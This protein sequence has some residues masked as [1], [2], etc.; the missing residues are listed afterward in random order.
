MSNLAY[1]FIGSG[2]FDEAKQLCTKAKENSDYNERIDFALA[3]IS[4][5]KTE[6]D[7]KE[8]DLVNNTKKIRSFYIEYAHTCSKKTLTEFSGKFKGPDC[9]LDVIIEN[10]KF[11]AIGSFEKTSITGGWASAFA[12]RPIG[13][14]LVP[15]SPAPEE[16]KTTMV[17]EYNGDLVGRG[18]KYKLR[19]NEKDS[20]PT[21]LGDNAE[22]GL[23]I[24]LDDLSEIKVYQ[25]GTR[26]NEKYYS[27]LRIE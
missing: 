12:V 4:E 26:A 6:E 1:S 24:I 23:M 5:L 25:K 16:K 21:L 9:D 7:K 11:E 22:T 2:F 19:I 13:S 8:K 10:N 3:K 14:S 17:V 27:L 15:G 18:I 20:T